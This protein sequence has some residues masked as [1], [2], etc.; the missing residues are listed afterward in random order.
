MTRFLTAILLTILAFTGHG[1]ADSV[2]VNGVKRLYTVT[3]PATGCGGLPIILGFHGGFQQPSSFAA[4]AGFEGHGVQAI[5]VYPLGRPS[6]APTWNVGTVPPSVW[7]EDPNNENPIEELLFIRAILDT[8]AARYHAD[9]S[10]V[11]AT[12]ISNGGRMAWRL[13]CETPWLAGMAT[14][15]GTESDAACAPPT[16]TPILVISG[17]GDRIEPF[18]GGGSGGAGIPFSIGID[19]F[20]AIGASVTVLRPEGGGHS[21]AQPGIDTTETILSAWGMRK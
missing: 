9:L 19:L 20:R 7:A 21:W 5:M 2:N 13:A 4:A 8:L 1:R 15:A 17:T 16:P 3:C 14:V 10:R 6:L 11:Y 18:D 12:G